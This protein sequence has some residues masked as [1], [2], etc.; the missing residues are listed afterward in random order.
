MLCI[1]GEFRRE[2]PLT[3]RVLIKKHINRSS[4]LF[5]AC[6]LVLFGF[7]WVRVWVGT[8]FN[9]TQYQNMLDQLKDFEKYSPIDFASLLSYPGQVGMVYDEPIVIAC[10]VIWCVARGSD[11]VSGELGRGTMEMTLAQPISR[12]Q[13]LLTHALVSVAG[14][15]ILCG[16]VWG[17]I[18]LG[19]YTNV[20]SEEVPAPTYTIPV[21][22][23]DLQLGPS[24]P[25]VED[26]P[27][28][29]R[30]NWR[31]FAGAT[32]HLFSFGFVLLTFS[33]LVSSFDRYR[34]RT[35]GLVVGTY[36][37]QVV[38]YAL[39]LV[40]KSLAW[41]LGLTI[42]SCYKPQKMTAL[43][44]EHGIA[45]PF[46]MDS[47]ESNLNLGPIVYPLLLLTAGGVFLAVGTK[48]FQRRDLPAPL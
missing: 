19:I 21:L 44:A 48:I 7:A 34:W 14:L 16:L 22:N 10:I 42:L 46:G 3:N 11:A 40:S 18:S 13:L 30:V 12:R 47:F 24:E 33:I 15:A 35:V 17:G 31:L 2:L 37:I 28:H 43:A 1:L 5:M 9:L 39:G 27:L 38:L 41:M 20:V 36:V 8:F 29:E 26:V 4:L 6:G 32:F 45:A 25:I 23:I